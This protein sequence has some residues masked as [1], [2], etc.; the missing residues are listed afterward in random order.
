MR[1]DRLHETAQSAPRLPGVYLFK[2]SAGRVLYVG[3]AASLRDRLANY[4]GA[5]IPDKT[6]LF[7]T[8]AATLETILANSEYEA[9]LLEYNLIKEHRPPFN[10]IFRDDKRF[11]Y[12]KITAEDFP[13]VILTR[14]VEN[15]GAAYFGPFVSG[16]NVRRIIDMAYRFF[17]IR[18]CRRR[19]ADG[20]KSPPLCLQYHIKRC[21]GP[22]M[23]LISKAE[24]ARLVSQAHS[25]LRG[26]YET[27]I[28]ELTKQM[29]A[30]SNARNFELAGLY[31]DRVAAV[32]ELAEKQRAASAQVRD[33]D[34]VSFAADPN[35][36]RICFCVF[37]VR[38]GHII[39]SSA[40]VFPFAAA[41][42]SEALA[43]FLSEYYTLAQNIPG[44]IAVRDVPAGISSL[45]KSLA[46]RAARRVRLWTPTKG[47]AK[48]L[49]ML[50]EKNARARL[51]EKSDPQ[52]EEVL[53]RLREK[54]GLARRPECIH[55]YDVAN[56]GTH[57][58]TGARVVFKNGHAVKSLYRAYGLR[59]LGDIKDDYAAM[60]ELVSRSIRR[61][62]EKEPE[63]IPDLLLIDGG[64]GHVRSARKAVSSLSAADKPSPPPAPLRDASTPA[65][66][67]PAFEIVG[68]A[69]QEETLVMEDGRMIRL[70]RSDAGLNLLQRVRDEAHRFSRKLMA[71]RGG[72]R[73][74][75]RS[76]SS[77]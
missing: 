47:Y 17:R 10:I 16:L 69:K 67:R 26:D 23:G 43:H 27:L 58:V 73:M 20:R 25:F 14:R 9:F 60:E 56:L 53:D 50:A 34:A 35:R 65:S 75:Q 76:R 13:R 39:G 22:C 63:A 61:A 54:L 45:S 72:K 24:Y 5:Q 77:A 31:R 52:T 33:L 64:L 8:K 4:F 32:Q 44:E 28:T 40:F 68:L 46:S 3:K 59:E 1:I 21:D 15:D 55:G 42:E 71:T 57:T 18:T 11:P 74:L 19:I 38:K 2:D 36:G 30:A 37:R 66:V 51:Y 12:I 41:A 48:D 62:L 6:R 29:R 49:V 7:L 70:N